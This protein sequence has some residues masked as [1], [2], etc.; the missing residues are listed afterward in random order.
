[1]LALPCPAGPSS[2]RSVWLP[3][4]ENAGGG[5]T[6]DRPG[7]EHD[8]V[9]Y[10]QQRGT[11]AVVNRVYESVNQRLSGQVGSHGG[12][13]AGLADFAEQA[14]SVN[15][16]LPHRSLSQRAPAA[17]EAIVAHPGD[18]DLTRLRRTDRLGASSTST[19][20][21]TELDARDLAN[22]RSSRPPALSLW[23]SSALPRDHCS[24]YNSSVSPWSSPSSSTPP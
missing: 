21:S 11:G 24:S 12:H 18:V 3:P 22:K 23:C 19:G 7:G 5:E 16:P 9:A 13:P 6:A 1:M 20:W 2:E 15:F 17:C 4:E 10:L 8:H 14:G